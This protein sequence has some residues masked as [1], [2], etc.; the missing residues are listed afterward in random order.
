MHV[1]L[2]VEKRYIVLG[3]GTT[4]KLQEAVDTYIMNGW[5]PAGGIMVG[6]DHHGVKAFYQAIWLPKD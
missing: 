3:Y 5:I 6:T 4:K 1:D 2:R